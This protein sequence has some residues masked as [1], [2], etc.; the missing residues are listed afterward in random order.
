MQ[1]ADRIRFNPE[2]PREISFIPAVVAMSLAIGIGLVWFLVSADSFSGYPYLFLV[3]WVLGLA[4]VLAL[5]TVYLYYK[6]RFSFADPLIFAT[7]TYFFPAFVIGGFVL[8]GGWSQPHFLA[9]VD[10]VQSTLP[11]TLVLVAVGFA[12][13]TAGYFL[14]LGDRLGAMIAT[15]L[16]GKNYPLRSYT[17]PGVLL[18]LLGVMNT[19]IAFALGLFGFQRNI[20]ITQY[21]GLVYL[22]TLFW[23]QGSFLLWF[24][25]FRAPRFDLV[26]LPVIALLVSTG[27]TRIL[28]AGNRGT[29]IQIFT[30]VGLA[31]I[32]AGRRVSLKHSVIAGS[33]LSILLIFGMIYGTTFRNVKG[34]EM[35]QGADQYAEN[36]MSTFSEIG[37]SDIGQ[38]L[39][40]GFSNLAGRLDIVSTLAVVVSN[41]E[42]LKPYEEAYGLDNNIWVDSTTFLIPRIFWNDKPIASDVRKYSELYFHFG[43]N[44]FAITPMG[45]LLRNFGLLGIPIGMLILGVILRTI[46]RALVEKQKAVIWRLTLYFMLLT[47]VSY[48]GFFGT[49]IPNVVKVC[50]IAGVGI[51]IVSFLASLVTR[52]LDGIEGPLLK[53]R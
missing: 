24:L 4:V 43:E 20:E 23:I 52:Y 13:L 14:P 5:P 12:G 22:T 1:T 15:R 49:I 30:I 33:I 34:T 45:D 38:S 37:R 16:P 21:D 3:P 8:A 42:I 53:R 51:L 18:L 2:L 27:I 31:F 44:S 35:Y 39:E 25:L 46:Y 41:Y 40:F 36:V 28:F 9:F 32:L 48:E 19:V 17:V 26:F 7:W 29:I 6:G 11:L 10:D 50:F 47:A